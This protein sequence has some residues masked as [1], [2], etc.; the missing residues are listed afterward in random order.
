MKTDD[1]ISLLSA[2]ASAGPPPRRTVWAFLAAGA[3]ASVLLLL[4]SLK[5]RPDL[6]Q[7]TQSVRFLFKFVATLSLALPALWLARRCLSPQA[8]TDRWALPLLL[9][10]LLLV[11]AV[12]LE[13]RVLPESAW[14]PQLV[15]TNSRWCLGFVPIFS[16]PVLAALLLALKRGAPTRPRLAGLVAG[17]AA[18][19]IGATVYAIHCTDDSPLFV[20]F[21]YTIG[22]L[23]VAAIGAAISE[24]VLRW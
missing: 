13:L 20:A 19:G 7:A 5:P 14:M 11:S 8:S 17:L 1:L 23:I 24:R 15:G 3:A 9:A 21:W 22:I 16:M 18:G 10:P 6:A 4:V 2:E 12:G